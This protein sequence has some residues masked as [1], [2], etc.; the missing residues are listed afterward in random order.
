MTRIWRTAL[1]GLACAV[2]AGIQPLSA[3][4]PLQHVRTLYASAAYDDALSAVSRLAASDP[5]PEIEQ[6]RV[7]CLV[8]LG[9]TTEAEKVIASVVAANPA[10]VPDA[11]EMSPRIRE[12][13]S[14]VRL[15][16]VPEIAHRLYTEAR[17]SMDRKDKAAAMAKLEAVVRLIDGAAAERGNEPEEPL[18]SE[19][20]LLA[21]GFLDLHR[22]AEARSAPAPRAQPAPRLEVTAPVP[23]KQELPLWAPPDQN[24]RREFRGAVRVFIAADGHVTGAE[25]APGIHPVYDRVLLQAAK[26]WLYE[27]ARRNGTPVPSEKLIEVVL[28]PR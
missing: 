10:F 5:R 20:R 2:G 17:A 9:R 13:F 19:L 22:E 27:P 1:A 24:S 16:L 6:Y 4:D 25:V 3:Q 14:K 26:T 7:F 28:K 8:A 15:T 21:A 11:R 12:M 23:V 18:L